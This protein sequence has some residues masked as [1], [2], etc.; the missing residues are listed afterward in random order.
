MSLK[1]ECACGHDIDTHYKDPVDGKRYACLGSRC[2]CAR[3]DEG[4]KAKKNV[5]PANNH[6]ERKTAAGGGR[7]HVSCTCFACL[8]WEYD[9]M[10][11]SFGTFSGLPW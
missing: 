3:Y 4:K 11:G 10:L 6:D 1:Q 2:D 9:K 7:P 8:K 5:L